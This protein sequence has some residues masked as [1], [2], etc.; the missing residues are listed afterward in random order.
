MLHAL[1]I[2]LLGPHCNWKK[3]EHIVCTA[4]GG[5]ASPRQCVVLCCIARAQFCT[6]AALLAGVLSAGTD[7]FKFAAAAAAACC[8]LHVRTYNVCQVSVCWHARSA[9]AGYT[10]RSLF[11]LC[12]LL[13]AC[14]LRLA[15]AAIR[16]R[17][18]QYFSLYGLQ[19]Q[20]SKQLQ[21]C[22][23]VASRT[24]PILLRW[25]WASVSLL[26]ASVPPLQACS[27]ASET[28]AAL[29]LQTRTARPEPDPSFCRVPQLRLRAL[30]FCFLG[31]PL[32]IC[33]GKKK[34]TR[35]P[36]IHLHFFVFASSLF[37]FFFFLLHDRK[38][39]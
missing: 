6:V 22:R 1:Q 2:N 39:K 15:A 10:A 17:L 7:A 29:P 28:A 23:L 20:Q 19:L 21:Q 11:R 27:G 26:R 36:R 33:Q 8:S 32:Q 4:A 34:K 24:R 25:G 13:S 31:P 12:R 5:A 9:V 35:A 18:L 38:R 30:T 3:F 14:S 16:L 37:P